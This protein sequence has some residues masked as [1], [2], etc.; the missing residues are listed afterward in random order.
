MYVQIS[1]ITWALN[2]NCFLSLNVPCLWSGSKVSIIIIII[3]SSS[4][5]SSITSIIII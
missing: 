4:S 2:K 1:Q 5:S 3:S